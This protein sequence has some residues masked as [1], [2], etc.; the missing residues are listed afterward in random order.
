MRSRVETSLR[1]VARETL[2][3]L[4]RLVPAERGS[5]RIVYYHRIDDERHRSCVAP[6]AFAEQMRL[7]RTEGYRVLPLSAVREHL[8]ARRPFP[9][10]SVAITFDDGFADNHRNALP[11]LAREGHPATLFLAT[12]YVGTD[13]LPVIRDRRGLRPLDWSQVEEMSRGGV[14]MGAHTI[15]HPELPGLPDDALRREIV[16]SKEEIEHRLGRP[17]SSFCY[18]RGRFD[19]RVERAVADAGFAIACTTLP[20]AVSPGDAPFR[21]RRTFVARDDGPRDFLH[22]LAGTWD[23]LHAARQRWGGARTPAPA[24]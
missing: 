19:A 22:K 11:V 21:L 14:E 23:A 13:E 20:G 17:V 15:S 9:E 16:G 24:C 7:L 5:L 12:G 4:R 6:T 2:G 3:A 18:P 10:R 8:S 1:V